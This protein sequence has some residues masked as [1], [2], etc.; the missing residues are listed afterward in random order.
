M[1]RKTAAITTSIASAV[2]ASGTLKHSSRTRFI[3]PTVPACT[4]TGPMPERT[5]RI[6]LTPIAALA[7][8]PVERSVK[9]FVG[10]LNSRS[11]TAGWRVLSM[12][13][14]IRRMVRFWS[15]MKAADTMP[16]TMTASETCTMRSFSA[17]GT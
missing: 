3:T 4:A 2:S 14:S 11:H 17:R 1:V 8:S 9:N 13:P 5:R 6:A 10:S 15:S 7:S 16:V 12:R